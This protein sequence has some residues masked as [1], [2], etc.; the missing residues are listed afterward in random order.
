MQL[1]PKKLREQLFIHKNYDKWKHAE[2]V[3]AGTD[4][5]APD[6][7]AD[8][9]A[10]VSAD[11]SFVQ[12]H[13]PDSRVT[14]YLNALVE[15]FY[16]NIHGVRRERNTRLI[17]FWTQEVPA[18]LYAERRLLLASLI[19]FLVAV[20]AGIVSQ[21]IDHDFCML[22]LGDSYMYVTEQNIDSGIPMGIYGQTE[23]MQMFGMISFN[24]IWVA[25]RCFASGI[26]TSIFTCV[27]LVQNGLMIGCFDTYFAQRGILADCLTAT[28][29]HGTL[30][31]SAIVIAG[32]GGL[33]LGNAWLF[34]GTYKRIEALRIGAMRGLKIVVTSVPLLIVAAFIESFLTR[35]TE[36]PTEIKLSVI[37][38]SACFIAF[39]YIVWPWYLHAKDK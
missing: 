35:H 13:W 31:L 24:N 14:T 30:E 17:T 10:D 33:A 2:V 25:L 20:L 7:V 39:Y 4:N 23:S 37:I 1:K 5:Y 6:V 21:H 12:S 19:I 8:V 3:A 9:Y 29:L 34:P 18:V 15:E 32:A 16:K 36:M 11:L 28:M 22:I 27:I 38:L 26:L